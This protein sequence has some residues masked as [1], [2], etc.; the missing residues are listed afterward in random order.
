MRILPL[1]AALL[2][3]AAL[4]PPRLFAAHATP[5]DQAPSPSLIINTDGIPPHSRADG[6]G[7]EDRIV[8]EAFRRIGR[9]I[10]ISRLSS[11]ERCIRNVED[12][13]DDGN[14]VRVAGVERQ[15]PNIIMVPEPVSRYSFTAFTRE[16]G[17]ASL[18]W[19]ELPRY[20][21]GYA[22]GWKAVEAH[23]K[24]KPLAVAARDEEALFTLLVGGRVDV[25]VSGLD[26]GNEIIRQRGYKRLRP[27]LPPLETRDMF[28]YLNRRHAGLVPGLAEALRQMRKDGTMSR[29]MREGGGTAP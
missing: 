12:G 8:S 22:V 6:S 16:D 1:A 20:H 23:L 19:A 28:L 10:V 11:S 14:Y 25:I 9:S 7:F 4:L 15:Y 21:T 29:L 3:L 26:G 27:V 24:N 2:C 5:P 18:T 17:P 13:F